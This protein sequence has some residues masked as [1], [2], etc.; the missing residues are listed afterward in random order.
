MH[1]F[2]SELKLGE[3]GNLLLDLQGTGKFHTFSNIFSENNRPACVYSE[4]V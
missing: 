3:F 1:A 4:K 2:E